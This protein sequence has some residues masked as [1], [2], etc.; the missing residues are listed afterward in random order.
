MTGR[1]STRRRPRIVGVIA[2]RDGLEQA[3]R[4]RRPPDLFELR[5][6]RL[7]GVI[8]QVETKLPKLRAPLIITA[9]H[10]DEGGS[11]RLSLRQRRALLSRFLEYADYLDIE[12]RSANLLRGLLA[13]AKTKNVRRIISFHDFKST[14]SARLLVAKAHNAKA[15]GADIFKVATRTDTPTELGRLLEFITKNR[16]NVRLAVMGIGRLGAISRVLLA[17][18]GSVL[19]YASLG[20][21]IDVEGQLSLEQLRALGF[22]PLDW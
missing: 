7:A 14:P 4:M 16:V 12:L 11:G 3:L 10:P 5:L 18:A 17:R 22:G 2:S 9:R 6:D 1:R 13:V 19:I 15:L 8:D 20:P 21:A